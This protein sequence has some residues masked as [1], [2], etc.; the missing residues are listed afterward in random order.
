MLDTISADSAQSAARLGWTGVVRFLHLAPRAFL[1][2][3]AA[4]SITLVAGRG[5]EGD[6]YMI[7]NEEGFY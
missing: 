3:R 4:E 2:M 5:I 6:R 1:P 7:G